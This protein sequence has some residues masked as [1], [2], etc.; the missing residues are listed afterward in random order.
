MGDR[1]RPASSRPL[2]CLSAAPRTLAPVSTTT[3]SPVDLTGIDA[4]PVDPAFTELPLRQLADAALS[5]ATAAGA[6]YADFRFERSV[7][8]DLTIRD[9]A[10]QSATNAVTTG[11]AVRVIVDGTWGFAASVVPT[12]GRGGGAPHGRRSRSPG[13]WPGWSRSGWSGPTSPSTPMRLGQRATTSTRSPSPPQDK[14]ALLL[15]RSERLLAADGVA[16]TT[17]GLFQVKENKFYA[18]TRRHGDHP[19]AGPAAALA[20]GHRGGQCQRARSRRCPA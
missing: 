12:A 13:R 2:A 15:D 4:P 6:S 1:H 10:V 18:D 9:T 3:D 7:T 5:A 11:Y 16:H 20:D 8:A 17:A 19:A 14:I